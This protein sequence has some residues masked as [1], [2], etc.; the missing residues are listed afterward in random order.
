[1]LSLDISKSGDVHCLSCAALTKKS[2][3]P[4]FPQEILDCIIDEL[5]DD[6]SELKA[7]CL[8]HR[9]LLNRSRAIIHRRVVITSYELFK[10]KYTSPEVA[11]QVRS[12][13]LSQVVNITAATGSLPFSILARFPN[14]EWL[15]VGG[16]EWPKARFTS[17]SRDIYASLFPLVNAM[18]FT[19]AGPFQSPEAMRDSLLF[20]SAFPSLSWLTL[21]FFEDTFTSDFTWP[22]PIVTSSDA[23][24]PLFPPCMNLSR[25][26]LQVWTPLSFAHLVSTWLGRVALSREVTIDCTLRPFNFQ[27][28]DVSMLQANG[29]IF[30]RV[31]D[32]ILILKFP[33]TPISLAPVVLQRCASLR[34]LQLIVNWNPPSDREH[35]SHEIYTSLVNSIASI[36]SK[37]VE[38][39]S[40]S[41]DCWLAI[42]VDDRLDDALAK[43]PGLHQVEFA[44]RRDFDSKFLE[45]RF[46]TSLQL[47]SSRISLTVL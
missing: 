28:R 23:S 33:M 3:S 24:A 7:C 44:V 36:P 35:L 30:E 11:R 5:K 19:D 40:F 37:E 20:L 14:V 6:R 9:L 46:W 12:L 42:F 45:E 25:L 47:T 2:R 21:K 41:W 26:S 17:E 16:T 18:K 29:A 34:S 38:K 13:M 8:A 27:D 1:M 39:I 43:L 31:H 4:A 15:T 32:L 10:D 22:T